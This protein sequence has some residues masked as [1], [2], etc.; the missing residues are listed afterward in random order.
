[1]CGLKK[2]HN[3]VCFYEDHNFVYYKEKLEIAVL[4]KNVLEITKTRIS[5]LKP[6]SSIIWLGSKSRVTFLKMSLVGKAR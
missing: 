5:T 1:M 6:Q 4:G 3:V 2:V